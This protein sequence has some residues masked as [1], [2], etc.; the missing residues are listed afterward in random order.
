MRL[1]QDNGYRPYEL[2][3]FS[4]AAR[5]LLMATLTKQA[6]PLNDSTPESS[7]LG[8]FMPGDS[9]TDNMPLNDST[10]ESSGLGGFM[11]APG[12]EA[13]LPES[14]GDWAMRQATAAGKHIGENPIPYGVGGGLGLGALMYLL[15]G[16]KK[17]SRQ[18]YPHLSEIQ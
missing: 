8:G 17:K 12:T 2:N 16:R 1:T 6:E 15:S 10:P 11:P 9:P 4:K 18:H 5:T 7:G 13:V 3:Q 14:W